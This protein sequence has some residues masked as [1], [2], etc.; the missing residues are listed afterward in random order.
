MLADKGLLASC[1]VLQHAAKLCIMQVVVLIEVLPTSS[2]SL[3]ALSWVPVA[4]TVQT[5]KLMIKPLAAFLQQTTN[6]QSS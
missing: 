6:V 1:Q 4:M 5:P 3:C 2:G